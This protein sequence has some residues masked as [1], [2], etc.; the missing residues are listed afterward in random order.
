[1]RTIQVVSERTFTVVPV[2]EG[3]DWVFAAAKIIGSI[4]LRFLLIDWI[5]SFSLKCR[6][7]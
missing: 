7:I 3:M 6:V 5:M 4:K 2:I 1:M